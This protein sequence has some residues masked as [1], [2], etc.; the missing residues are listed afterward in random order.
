MTTVASHF[1]SARL[2][3]KA[4][5]IEV[6]NDSRETGVAVIYMKSS[7]VTRSGDVSCQKIMSLFNVAVAVCL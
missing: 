4:F 7:A 6:D 2:R 5:Y 3:Y 1:P